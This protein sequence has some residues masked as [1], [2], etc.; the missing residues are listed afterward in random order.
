M[1]FLLLLLKKI[2]NPQGLD[3]SRPISMTNYLYKML[4]KVLSSRIKKVLPKVIDES[5]SIFLG[6]RNM[7]DEVIV[8]NKIIHEMK[9]KKQKCGIL[10]AEFEKVYDSVRWQ[11]LYG[12]NGLKCSWSFPLCQYLLTGAQPRSS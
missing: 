7:F 11:F 8:A 3:Y 6:G 12:S 4:A 10:K 5:Q 1:L 9:I 2:E